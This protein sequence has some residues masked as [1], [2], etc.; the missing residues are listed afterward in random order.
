MMICVLNYE[1]PVVAKN[2]KG[3]FSFQK[4]NGEKVAKKCEGES[5]SS[6]RKN[7]I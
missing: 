4:W 6:F 1:I 7:F 5:R 2:A 3:S